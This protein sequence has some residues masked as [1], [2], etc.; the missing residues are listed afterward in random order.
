MVLSVGHEVFLY[1]TMLVDLYL[2]HAFETIPSG[3]VFEELSNRLVCHIGTHT[4][5]SLRVEGR[6]ATISQTVESNTMFGV[7]VFR[8][9]NAPSFVHITNVDS[10][11]AFGPHR[12]VGHLSTVECVLAQ[13]GNAKHGVHVLCWV[14]F[15][16]VHNAALHLVCKVQVRSI[17]SLASRFGKRLGLCLESDSPCQT[18]LVHD[19]VSLSSFE[20]ITIRFAIS[21]LSFRRQLI[22]VNATFKGSSLGVVNLA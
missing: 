9:N 18:A 8:S 11:H 19:S 14:K 17:F 2:A 10:T 1:Q 3:V 21:S 4:T 13:S 6:D 16:A 12:T 22:K 20:R 7:L 5:D 15:K